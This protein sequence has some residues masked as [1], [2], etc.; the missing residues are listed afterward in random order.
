M[1]DELER[2]IYDGEEV[3][4]FLSTPLGKKLIQI[5]EQEEKSSMQ[6]LSIT[7][8]HNV[9]KMMDIQFDI[10]VARAVPGWLQNIISSGAVAYQEYIDTSS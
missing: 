3:K 10:R 5:A 8:P 2:A 9:E 4:K 7:D 6:E 1:G